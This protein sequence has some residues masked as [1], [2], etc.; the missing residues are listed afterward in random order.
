MERSLYT[1]LAVMIK[2]VIAD[3]SLQEFLCARGLLNPNF[4]TCFEEKVIHLGNELIQW[5]EETQEKLCSS[6]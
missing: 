4:G 2:F 5:K 1:Q 3:D 6:S